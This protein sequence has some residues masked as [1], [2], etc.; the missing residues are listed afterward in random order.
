MEEQMAQ[1]RREGI[2]QVQGY[3]ISPPRPAAEVE[4]LIARFSPSRLAG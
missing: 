1:V 4:K 3:F 2:H